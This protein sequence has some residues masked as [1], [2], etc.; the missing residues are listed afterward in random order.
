[1]KEKRSNKV[2]KERKFQGVGGKED[3]LPSC[4]FVHVAIEKLF[5]NL[6]LANPTPELRVEVLMQLVQGLKYNNMDD[7]AFE[8]NANL[9]LVYSLSVPRWRW[10]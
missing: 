7:V 6:E 10:F 2:R 9:T 8:T 5:A 3:G 1:M 4:E